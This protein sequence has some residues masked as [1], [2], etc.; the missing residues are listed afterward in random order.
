MRLHDAGRELA[1]DGRVRGMRDLY[2]VRLSKAYARQEQ[3]IIV[4]KRG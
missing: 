2:A 4:T 1:A 3:G